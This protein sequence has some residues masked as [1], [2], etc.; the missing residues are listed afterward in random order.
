[1]SA[2][3][4]IIAI[5]SHCCASARYRA[6]SALSPRQPAALAARV[7]S[8]ALVLQALAPVEQ[9]GMMSPDGPSERTS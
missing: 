9:M 5:S 4:P 6:L 8:A 3:S 2:A 1:M 7:H